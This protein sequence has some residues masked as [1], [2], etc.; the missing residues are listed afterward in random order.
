MGPA[1]QLGPDLSEVGNCDLTLAVHALGATL[2]ILH[3]EKRVCG[4]GGGRWGGRG[5]GRGGVNGVVLVLEIVIISLIDHSIVCRTMYWQGWFVL[6]CGTRRH[7]H[8]PDQSIRDKS[9]TSNVG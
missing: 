7:F 1:Q 9:K 4:G 5:K 8:R 2:V 6:L 3:C